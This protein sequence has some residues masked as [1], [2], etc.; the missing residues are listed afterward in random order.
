VKS[1]GHGT[2]TNIDAEA[3]IAIAQSAEKN[4]FSNDDF[5]EVNGF[6]CGERVEIMPTDYG[7]TP[8]TGELIVSKIDEIAIKRVDEKAGEVYVHFPRVGYKI[9]AA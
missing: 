9:V 4:V 6:K 3:A 5:L 1:I 7:I 8:V 2:Q